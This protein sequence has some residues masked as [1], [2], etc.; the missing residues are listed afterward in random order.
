M[1]NRLRSQ[2]DESSVAGQSGQKTLTQNDPILREQS[3]RIV[4]DRP[5]EEVLGAE[6]ALA[7]S[8]KC[9][10]LHRKKAP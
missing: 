8:N 3:R 7:F 1:T 2:L 10:P 4:A 6:A 5:M 9:Y